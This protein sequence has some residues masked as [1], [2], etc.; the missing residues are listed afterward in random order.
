MYLNKTI[1]I[2]NMF[3]LNIVIIMFFHK[4]VVELNPRCFH[5][6]TRSFCS[7]NYLKFITDAT[8]NSIVYLQERRL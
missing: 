6:Y 8:S 3:I 7:K 1:H 4:T 5:D 2:Y